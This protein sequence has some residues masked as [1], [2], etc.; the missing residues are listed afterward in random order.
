MNKADIE[1]IRNKLKE[2]AQ[3]RFG[4]GSLYFSG[5][6]ISVDAFCDAKIAEAELMANTIS[7]Y[8]I[9]GRSITKR[10]ISDIPYDALLADLEN[11][12]DA[13]EIP[14]RLTSNR[15]IGVDFSRGVV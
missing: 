14:F 2:I 9:Q 3:R 10:S 15:A 6:C 13:S 11:F 7:S 1:N 8:S 4:F 5:A 12:F